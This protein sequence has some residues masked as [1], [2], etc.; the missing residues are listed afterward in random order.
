M[1]VIHKENY[2][3]LKDTEIIKA[4]SSLNIYKHYKQ[5]ELIYL[6]FP[7]SSHLLFCFICVEFVEGK[8]IDGMMV[9]NKGK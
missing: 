3:I 2:N 1:T 9:E 5:L 7:P 6:Y 4:V 8:L